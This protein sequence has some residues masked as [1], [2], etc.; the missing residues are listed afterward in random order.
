MTAI[1]FLL[2]FVLMLLS[3]WL[4]ASGTDYRRWFYLGHGLVLAVVGLGNVL[5]ILQM[6]VL[7]ILGMAVMVACQI[8][9]R[10]CIEYFEQHVLTHIDGY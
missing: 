7:G 1:I 3:L 9:A 5:D 8:V 4:F 2:C 10:F 6:Q